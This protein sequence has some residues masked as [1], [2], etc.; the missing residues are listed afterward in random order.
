MSL[1]PMTL[2]RATDE[3]RVATVLLS[4][5]ETVWGRYDETSR[6]VRLDE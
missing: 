3:G 2:L 1:V 5:D 4:R 6:T